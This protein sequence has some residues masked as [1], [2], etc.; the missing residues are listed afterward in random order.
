MWRESEQLFEIY[1]DLIFSVTQGKFNLLKDE[2]VKTI[3]SS[4]DLY[5]E[6]IIQQPKDVSSARQKVEEFINGRVSPRRIYPIVLC[7]SEAATNVVTHA[8][9]GIM[10]LRSAEGLLRLIFY[11][12]GPGIELAQLA[13]MLLSRGFST[14][15][16]MG[17]GFSIINEYTD[18][19]YLSTSGH[20]T[21]L[22]LEFQ[23]EGEKSN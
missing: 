16:S 21:V 2:E 4:G 3:M 13:R 23:D 15:Q 6:A 17:Y 9:K 5:G 12:Q 8:G 19:V 10:Q 7:A 20:G 11:D 22:I 1:S 18:K 14:K